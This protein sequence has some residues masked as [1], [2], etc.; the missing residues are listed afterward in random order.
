VFEENALSSSQRQIGGRVC[1]RVDFNRLDGATGGTRIDV[2]T[3]KC[4]HF[5]FSAPQPLRVLFSA[6]IMQKYS[7]LGVFL[8]QVKAV[9][10]AL[11]KVWSAYR[12]LRS[13]LCC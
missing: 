3:M 11:V 12:S 10:S 1:V 13:L 4:L 5:T 2:A 7:R 6:S 8:I 9:E